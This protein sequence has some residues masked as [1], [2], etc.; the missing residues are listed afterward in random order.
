ML[1]RDKTTYAAH[2]ARQQKN[3]EE[4]L[5]EGGYDHAVVAAGRPHEVF[6]DDNEYPFKVNPH[7]NVWAPLT[8]S[9][10]SFLLIVPG[11]KPRLVF[12][13][14]D[15]Y[16]HAAPA[17]PEPAI[18]EQFDLHRVSAI[19][20]IPALLK[21]SGRGAFL[22][23]WEQRYE[24]WNLGDPNP[25]VV[26]DWLHYHRAWKTEYE[27][28]CMREASRLGARAHIA[29][30]DAF[31]DGASEFDINAAYMKACRHSESELPYGNIVAINEHAAV[32][33]YQ[34]LDRNEPSGA[35]R[36]SFLI[37]AGAT[38][39]G[40]AC[41]ITRSYAARAGI[42]AD[43]I[44]AMET[45]QRAMCA[46]IRPGVSFID[47]HLGAHEK[48]AAV[49]ADF[50]IV[51]MSAEDIVA[52][53]VSSTFFPHGLGHYLG[54]QVHD[55]GGLMAGPD[56]SVI[57]RPDGHPFLRLTRTL[58]TGQVTTIEPGLYFIKKLLKE[59]RATPHASAVNWELVDELT[60]Y[61]GIRIEDDVVV[62]DEGP[63]NLTRDAFAALH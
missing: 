28:D 17:P 35:D 25:A 54:L 24:D 33:H 41:D 3:F 57:A 21:A 8:A 37:D 61:G 59:L 16:W 62:G 55:T 5:A 53:G 18:S 30:R 52:S 10:E 2:I 44:A 40:Y 47:M 9:P 51:S 32:L 34:H 45:A 49:L 26:L 15:D 7:F 31:F 4:A 46:Q 13:S 58:E 22:G 43:M 38:Y 20:E 63:E 12:Y 23:E 60:P 19:S 48:I 1:I 50:G 42:F 27:L 56:G 29:A 6:L 39:A 11:Q 14:P 36:R